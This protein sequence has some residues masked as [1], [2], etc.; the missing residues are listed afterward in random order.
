MAVA[1]YSDSLV[2]LTAE[3]L[4]FRR[5]YFLFGFGSKTVPLSLVERI[6][7]RPPTLLNGK[8]RLW[9]SSYLRRWFPADWG[10]PKRDAILFLVMR[11][12]TFQ[13][14]FTVKNTGDFLKAAK[15]SGI[16][17]VE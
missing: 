9:G 3:T 12:K 5:Y 6:E 14:G 8:W 15:A 7:K 16:A 4:V 13:I 1:I 10:R 11:G 17:V 2:E